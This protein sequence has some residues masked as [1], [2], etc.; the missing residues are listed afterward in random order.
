MCVYAWN[1]EESGLC[2]GYL[3][4]PVKSTGSWGMI[5]NLL[6]RSCSPMVMM[7]TPSIRMVPAAGS[8]SLNRATPKEDFPTHTEDHLHEKSNPSGL[9]VKPRW[10]LG[11][12]GFFSRHFLL[13]FEELISIALVCM[14][15]ISPGLVPVVHAVS[16]PSH[17]FHVL[18]T[19]FSES[20]PDSLY[21]VK[22][23]FSFVNFV[24]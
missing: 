5:D 23:D 1:L 9:H 10:G 4:V 12:W 19:G 18:A 11:F 7:S 15:C 16:H 22:S 14:L 2:L 8:T 3:T 20:K 21:L 24:I 13:Y 6:R 17:S